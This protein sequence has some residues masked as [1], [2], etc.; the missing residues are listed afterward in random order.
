MKIS[1][2]VTLIGHIQFTVPIRRSDWPHRVHL[3]DC[4][5]QYKSSYKFMV[6]TVYGTTEAKCGRYFAIADNS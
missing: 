3:T 5:A 4:E 2:I 1:R 6:A